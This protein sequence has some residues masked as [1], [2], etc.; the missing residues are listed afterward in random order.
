MSDLYPNLQKT[1]FVITYGRSGSTLLQNMLNALPGHV[2]R[3]ENANLLAPL[4]RAW[5]GLCQSEQGAKMRRAAAPSGPHQP[6]YGYEAIDPDGLGRD[7][8]EVF[9]RDVLRPEPDTRVIGF[10]EIRWHTEPDFFAPMLEFL[11]RYMPS[12]HFIFNTR[13]HAQVANS[14]WWKTMKREVVLAELDR[15]E[16]LYATWQ[17]DH[18]ECSLAMHYN[19]YITG[20]EAWR[21]L[22]TFLD[23]PF[24]ADLVQ[25]VLDRKL[26]HMKWQPGQQAA[27]G[28]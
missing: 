3:G 2:L 4:V 6:W 10:K 5:H 7:L 24:D 14:G 18:P 9:L 12:A 17:A 27:P 13:A 8:A 25:A 22:F 16:A 26:M 11:R 28:G 20:P 1:V 23:Q 15:A 19:D 21:G